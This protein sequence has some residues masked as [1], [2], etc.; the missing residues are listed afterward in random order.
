[1]PLPDGFELGHWTDPEARTGCTVVLAP[2]GARGGVDVRGG[3]TGTR[4]L[5]SLSPLAN[6]EGPDAVLL[7]GGSAFGLAAADGVSRWLEERGR[8]R[9][10]PAGVVP[11]VPAAV[12]YDLVEGNSGSAT[13]T[14]AGLRGVRAARRRTCRSAVRS[15]PARAPPWASCSAA[16][17]PPAAEWATRRAR[18]A[19]GDDRGRGRGRQRVRGRDRRATV[20]CSAPRAANDGELVRTSTCSRR[21]R[22]C[23]SFAMSPR[24]GRQHDAGVRLHRRLDRQAQLRDR[25]ADGQRRDRACGRSRVH[26]D[27]RRCRLLYRV[28]IRAAGRRPVLASW[29]A[30]RLGAVAATSPPPRSATPS[31]PPARRSRART[32]VRAQQLIRGGRSSGTSV[33]S[34][35]SS[36]NWMNRYRSW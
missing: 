7:T 9:P 32:A 29:S 36:A 35:N 14:R 19:G 10:T 13:R 26:P 3:G 30:H 6:A 21:C 24:V 11:L 28:G 31:W 22:S 34:T 1:M 27:R 12:V 15:A 23:R 25:R 5:E 18:L 20:S 33:R 2:P 17:A 8:G 16:I 4:E